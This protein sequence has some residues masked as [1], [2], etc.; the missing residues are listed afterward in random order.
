M[1]Q[2][3]DTMEETFSCITEQHLRSFLMYRSS[4]SKINTVWKLHQNV[5]RIM[6]WGEKLSPGSIQGLILSIIDLSRQILL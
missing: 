5:A 2:V 4:R 3:V 1:R 6:L